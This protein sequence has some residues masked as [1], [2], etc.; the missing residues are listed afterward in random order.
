VIGLVLATLYLHLGFLNQLIC[1]PVE[2]FWRPFVGFGH[3][4]GCG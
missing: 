2:F 3:P 4:V 1:P